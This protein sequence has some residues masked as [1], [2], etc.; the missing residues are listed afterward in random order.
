MTTPL[1]I[2]IIGAGFQNKGAEAMALTFIHEIHQRLYIDTLTVASYSKNEL[3][4]WGSHKCQIGSK[5][6]S[7]ELVHNPSGADKLLGLI[8]CSQ[9]PFWKAW[10][11]ADLIV[12]LSGFAM[13]DNR[14]LKRRLA[15]TY[16]I[17]SARLRGKKIAL[18]TQAFGPFNETATRLLAAISLPLAD[19]I[20][21][22]DEESVKALRGCAFFKRIKKFHTAPD[23]ALLLPN[24]AHKPRQTAKAYGIVPNI[25]LYEKLEHE[26]RADSYI[27]LLC[28]VALHASTQFNS[29]PA[30]IIHEEYP[31]RK[32]DRWIAE[33]CN[34]KLRS[35]MTIP[36]ICSLS[37][38][39]LREQTAGLEFLFASRYH[40]IVGAAAQ[41]IPFFALG[42]A[43]KYEM[44][45]NDLDANE[46][47]WDGLCGDHDAIIKRLD[48]LW[49]QRHL[50]AEKLERNVKPLKQEASRAFDIL[51]RELSLQPREDDDD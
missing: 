26:G 47:S 33:Q 49:H 9:S 11:K 42:W 21:V 4:A 34:L 24:N 36:V 27:E 25:R 2:L 14:P 29:N 32:D 37:A 48:E 12:D 30:F 31:D 41:S 10:R 23:S 28:K 3:K 44:L 17:C 8:A 5:Q 50:L 22:R 43:H 7:F 51:I 35:Q 40:A 39:E 38:L 20:Y 45:A 15:Y 19:S 18:F 6:F 46:A 1:N 16:E 13:S